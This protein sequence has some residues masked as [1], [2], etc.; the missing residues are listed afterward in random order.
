MAQLEKFKLST[1]VWDGDK[2]PKGF[3]IWVENVGS[4]V[5]ATE[6]GKALEDMLDSKLRRKPALNQNVPTFILDDLDFGAA[7]AAP[8]E[9]DNTAAKVND[10]D[11]T[12]IGSLF[13]MGEQSLKYSELSE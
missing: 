12:S 7:Q 5:R 11:V 10:D 1:Y 13:T 6:H 3:N 8:A 9:G 4:M 2:D